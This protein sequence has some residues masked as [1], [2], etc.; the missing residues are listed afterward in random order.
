M[1]AECEV[2]LANLKVF[3]DFVGSLGWQWKPF[4]IW[5]AFNQPWQSRHSSHSLVLSGKELVQLAV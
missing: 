3:G 1:P 5:P 4:L 2:I